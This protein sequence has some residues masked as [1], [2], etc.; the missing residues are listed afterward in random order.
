M[1]VEEA[2]LIDQLLMVERQIKSKLGE[3]NHL[4]GREDH[5]SY[6]YGRPE[7]LKKTPWDFAKH[8]KEV[9]EKI[10]AKNPK[11]KSQQAMV[12]AAEAK[13][14]Y[15]RWNYLPDFEFKVGYTFRKPSPGDRGVDFVSGMV[16]ITLPIWALSRQSE[17][18]RGA[19]AEKMKAQAIVDEERIE[20][21]HMV[22]VLVA[23]L[24]ETNKRLQLFEKGVLP[25]TK[26]AV[27][28]AKSAY[29]TNKIEYST[30]LNLINKRF[31]MEL[32]YFE[33][34]V[35]HESKIA[36]LE[37]LVGERGGAS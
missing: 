14:S 1:Q 16:G 22:H 2:N 31:Q 33:A 34:L 12:N 17:E 28:S 18:K 26:Q 19:E 6:L 23:E 36:E 30:L 9:A 7:D 20:L 21:A 24:D 37:A 4:L 35:T 10:F 29:L 27:A 15:T 8:E 25:M 13:L 32:T 5:D 11:L 3:L